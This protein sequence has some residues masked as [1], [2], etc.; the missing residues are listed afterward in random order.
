[1]PYRKSLTPSLSMNNKKQINLALL[2]VTAQFMQ[3][4]PAFLGHRLCIRESVLPSGVR[5]A[6]D[7]LQGHLPTPL[8][9]R[10]SQFEEQC[11]K[12]Y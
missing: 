4:I 9:G 1:M 12:A 2:I 5:G 8:E 3:E 11:S 7:G 6:G 10:A